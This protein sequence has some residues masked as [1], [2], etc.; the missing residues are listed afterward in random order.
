MA[1]SSFSPSDKDSAQSLEINLQK[2]S[3]ADCSIES[4]GF[5][6]FNSFIDVFSSSLIYRGIMKDESQYLQTTN[7]NKRH[8][9]YRPLMVSDR[10]VLISEWGSI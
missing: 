1:S 9:I 5:K 2:D 10:R 6:A 7:K 3:G 8:R 4:L